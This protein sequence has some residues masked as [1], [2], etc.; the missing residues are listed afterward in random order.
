M[1][2]REYAGKMYCLFGRQLGLV[3]R[4]WTETNKPWALLLVLPLACLGAFSICP[5]VSPPVK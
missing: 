3:A 5:W 4:T 1:R 2:W